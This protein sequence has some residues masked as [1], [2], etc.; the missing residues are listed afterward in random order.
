MGAFKFRLDPVVSLKKRAEDER[1]IALASAK[2]DLQKQEHRLVNLCQRRDTC[3]S[4][5]CLRTENG[6][7][8]K[9][10]MLMYHAY[11]EKLAEEIASQ[12]STVERSKADVET[13]RELLVESSR[14]KKTLENLKERMRLRH[15]YRLKR[16]EQASLDETA[17]KFHRR[18]SAG[19]LSWKERG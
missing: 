16:T 17:G 4:P 7:L 2:R 15:M 19:R 1:K 12:T 9:S 14:E 11:M 18:K 3:Q 13:K 8:D 6:G 5:E 10:A